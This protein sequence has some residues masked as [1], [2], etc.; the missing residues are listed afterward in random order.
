MKM[1]LSKFIVLVSALLLSNGLHASI[2]EAKLNRS[3]RTIVLNEICIYPNT[4]EPGWIE[5]CNVS[6]K[7]V[8][9]SGYTL[10]MGDGRRFI[11][12]EDLGK[13]EPN[14]IVLI[15]FD[16]KK[17]QVPNDKSFDNDNL[18]LLH[19][20]VEL[21]TDPNT[22]HDPNSKTFVFPKLTGRCSL[23]RP[24]PMSKETIADFVCWGGNE[25]EIYFNQDLLITDDARGAKFWTPG[26]FVPTGARRDMIGGNPPLP[27]GGSISRDHLYLHGYQSWYKSYPPDITPGAMNRLP[28]PVLRDRIS[29]V[30]PTSSAR[31][32]W[33]GEIRR[34]DVTYELEVAL[35][36]SFTSI[37]KKVAPQRDRHVFD[38][39]P[40][41]TYYW[42]VR[43]IRGQQV[44]S[45]SE[46]GIY[47]VL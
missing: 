23:Y 35:D 17:G 40:P 45:W 39:Q 14:G 26:R 29:S 8:D 30:A 36:K 5:L 10:L 47:R 16:G 7:S 33:W 42:R 2:A 13:V 31:L 11:L 20:P 12:E 24:G 1:Y 41:G 21:R 28:R 44:S 43:T 15:M 19:T 46:V 3:A 22:Q 32:G 18:T 9:V 34:Q 25:L 6:N 38:K 37:Y 27:R 4:G